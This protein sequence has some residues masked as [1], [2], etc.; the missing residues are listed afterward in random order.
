LSGAAAGRSAPRATREDILTWGAGTYIDRILTDRDSVLARWPNRVADPVRVWIDAPGDAPVAE[1]TA[2]VRDAFDAWVDT[3][4]PLRFRYVDAPRNAEIRVRWITM[5]ANRTGST[6]WHANRGGWLRDGE[7]TLATRM[8]LDRTLDARG[9]RAI[10]LHEIGHSIG[11][12]HSTDG[13]DIMA[14]LVR[15]SDLSDKDRATARLL[16]TFPAGRIR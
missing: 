7:I 14:P 8:P 2:A 6:T 1:F 15:V 10:A 5:F 4:V 12:S 13:H 3:G 9:V 11:L 16:Y